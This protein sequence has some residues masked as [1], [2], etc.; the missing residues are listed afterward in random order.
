MEAF[1]LEFP[2]T[3]GSAD[4]E[5]S[6]LIAR[7]HANNTAGDPYLESLIFDY[8]RHLFIS[9]SRPNFLPP[10]L[11]GKWAYSLSNAWRSDYHANI[12]LQMN[13]WPADQTGLGG[14]QTALWTTWLRHGRHAVRRRRSFCITLLAGLFTTRWISLGTLG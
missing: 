6:Q 5:T 2:D 7:Y 10:N 9:S 14:L 12:N 8:G 11:Q 3:Q 1:I 13:H 4:L